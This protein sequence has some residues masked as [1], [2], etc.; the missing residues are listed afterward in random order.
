MSGDIVS[1]KLPIIK[2]L[3]F[4]ILSK[5]IKVTKQTKAIVFEVHRCT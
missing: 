5:L 4:F 3:E 2:D 1:D